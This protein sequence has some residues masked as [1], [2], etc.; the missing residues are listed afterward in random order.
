ME[1]Y[2]AIPTSEELI[3]TLFE[4]LQTGENA[5]SKDEL[6]AYWNLTEKNFGLIAT[7]ELFAKLCTHYS[8]SNF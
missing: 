4:L 1:N 3:N 5:S 6:V 7:F 2:Y 8:T